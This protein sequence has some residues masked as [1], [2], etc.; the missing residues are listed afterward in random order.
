MSSSGFLFSLSARSGDSD[1]NYTELLKK[2][3]KRKRLTRDILKVNKEVAGS[4]D[5][6]DDYT[7]AL[8]RELKRKRLTR[9]ILKVDKEVEEL[10]KPEPTF[11]N[12]IQASLNE[13]LFRQMEKKV[14]PEFGKA[15]AAVTTGPIQY[16]PVPPE[17]TKIMAASYAATYL[18]LYRS[19][20]PE[21]KDEWFES[22]HPCSFWHI[23]ACLSHDILQKQG[24]SFNDFRGSRRQIKRHLQ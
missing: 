11:G 18:Q 1:D 9:D 2:V 4:D 16:G 15:M 8:K 19:L 3:L 21:T 5:L 14:I 10:E 7:E 12:R 13:E 24:L 17:L 23:S 6:D 22:V 20:G